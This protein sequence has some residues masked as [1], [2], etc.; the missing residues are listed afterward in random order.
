V[1]RDANV[2]PPAYG[3]YPVPRQAEHGEYDDDFGGGATPG[4]KPDSHSPDYSEP[5]GHAP[6]YDGQDEV[7]YDGTGRPDDAHPAAYH[8]H[9]EPGHDEPGHEDGPHDADHHTDHDTEDDS[10]LGTVGVC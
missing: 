7:P 4:D 6:S 1:G 10:D 3:D 2:E 8:G 5:A 9:D